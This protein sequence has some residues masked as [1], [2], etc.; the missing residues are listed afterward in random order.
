MRSISAFAILA[1][2]LAEGQKG[3]GGRGSGGAKAGTVA[4]TGKYKPASE[5]IPSL[6]KHTIYYP[7]NLAE[8]EKAPLITWGNSGCA[9]D[10]VGFSTFLSEIASHGYVIVVS[11]QG[12]SYTPS[13]TDKDMSDT[14]EWAFKNPAAVKY[15]IDTTRV[16]TSGQ[17][18]GGIQAVHVGAQDSRVTLI[19]VFNSGA[20]NAKDTAAVKQV[21]VPIGYFLGGPTDIAYSNVREHQQPSAPTPAN[22]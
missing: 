17:S 20:L 4:G 19:T 16:S 8:G 10:G 5:V 22:S 14:I 18:C 12:T 1:V 9:G 3:G 7:Q 21:K 6:A 11:G 2:G 13:S 15:N